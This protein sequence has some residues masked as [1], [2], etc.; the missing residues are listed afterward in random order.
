M[1]TGQGFSLKDILRKHSCCKIV[2]SCILTASVHK[3]FE[4]LHDSVFSPVYVIKYSC[5][6]INKIPYYLDL[7]RYLNSNCFPSC[8]FLTFDAYVA[9]DSTK[10]IPFA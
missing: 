4:S 6:T 3:Y 5:L 2:G 9:S 8:G 10:P 1:L 7:P